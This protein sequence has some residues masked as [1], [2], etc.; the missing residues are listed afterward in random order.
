[1]PANFDRSLSLD[2]ALLQHG[3]T[4]IGKG[5]YGVVYQGVYNGRDVAIKNMLKECDAAA[6]Q[7]F[8]DEATIM[9]N[10]PPH[11]NVLQFIGLMSSNHLPAIVMEFCAGSSLLN[12][13]QHAPLDEATTWHVV[14]GTAAG[15]AHLAANN[16]AHRDLACRNILLDGS[17]NPKVCDFGMSRMTWRETGGSQD[18]TKSNVGPVKWMAPEA[19]QFQKF[20]EK[21]DVWMF[22]CTVVELTTRKEPHPDMP[23]MQAGTQTIMNGLTPSFPPDA[24]PAMVQVLQ[25]CFLFSPDD[26]PTFAMLVQGLGG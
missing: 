17:W 25:Q 21:S 26:R 10:I 18:Q 6:M 22:G 12:A 5:E 9:A 15:M 3:T 1:L 19:L 13:I 20:S 16:I 8:L 7:E 4:V 14:R 24:P 23:S 2:P 11:A